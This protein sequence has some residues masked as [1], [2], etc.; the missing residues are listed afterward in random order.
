MGAVVDADKE[1]FEKLVDEGTV[2]VDVWGPD[3]QPC[4]ALMPTIDTLAEE[5]SDLKV[6]KVEAPKN[7]R[8]CMTL[9]VMGLPAYLLYVDGGEVSRLTGQDVT[10]AKLTAWLDEATSAA[11]NQAG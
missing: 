9:K 2:L 1:T 8:L 3:C 5:R 6:V 11:V 4:M 7:R 10:A